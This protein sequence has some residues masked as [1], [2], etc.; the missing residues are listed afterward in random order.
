MDIKNRIIEQKWDEIVL[1]AQTLLTKF[2][3]GKLL[4]QTDKEAIQ[5]LWKSLNYIFSANRLNW[6]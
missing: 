1:N 5:T 4:I 3:A 6:L 2:K